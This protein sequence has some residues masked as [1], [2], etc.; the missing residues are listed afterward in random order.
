MGNLFSTHTAKSAVTGDKAEVQNNS[1]IEEGGIHFLDITFNNNHGAAQM[2]MWMLVAFI[3][4]AVTC[5]LVLRC[6]RRW[7]RR[8]I[9]EPKRQMELTNLKKDVEAAVAEKEEAVQKMAIQSMPFNMPIP[10][11]PIMPFGNN[12]HAASMASMLMALGNRTSNN[13]LAL[14]PPSNRSLYTPE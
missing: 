9:G 2:F 1:K 4:G 11:A 3:V 5:F 12:N 6:Y 14:P 8:N 10:S 13:T 7:K